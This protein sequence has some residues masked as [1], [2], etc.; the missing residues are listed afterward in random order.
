M[1]KTGCSSPEAYE[2]NRDT[3][4]TEALRGTF[5]AVFFIGIQVTAIENYPTKMDNALPSYSV[6]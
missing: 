6:L 4:F 3:A 5:R 2:K 1:H